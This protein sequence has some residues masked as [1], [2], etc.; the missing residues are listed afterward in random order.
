MPSIPHFLANLGLKSVTNAEELI[1][2][3]LDGRVGMVGVIGR[4]VERSIER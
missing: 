1:V 2:K 4:R 3:V